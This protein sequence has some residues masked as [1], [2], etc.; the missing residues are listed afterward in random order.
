MDKKKFE[1]I[2]LLILGASLLYVPTKFCNGRA[3]ISGDWIFIMDIFGNQFLDFPR[4]AIQV[5]VVALVLFAYW[6]F[7]YRI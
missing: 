3:C 6:R 7:K 1:L 2:A 5:A 4:L